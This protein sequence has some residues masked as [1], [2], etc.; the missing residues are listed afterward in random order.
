MKTLNLQK[1]NLNQYIRQESYTHLVIIMKKI[2]QA[3]AVTTLVFML[4][5]CS[6]EASKATINPVAENSQE[7][8]IVI[9][10]ESMDDDEFSFVMPSA[11]QI[12][13]I[14]QRTGAEYMD[15]VANPA[16]N[17]PKYATRVKKLL[18]LGIFT[19]DLAYVVLNSQTQIAMDYL[20]T[21][22][23]LSDEV[24]MSSVFNS[25][26]LL[27]RFERNIGE[28]D[29]IISI[30]AEIQE[31]TD[32]YIR[33]SDQDHL[34]MIIF[35]GAWV[36]GMYIG[37]TTAPEGQKDVLV[38]RLLEQTII[39]KNLNKGLQQQPFDTEEINTVKASLM[40]LQAFFESIE[41]LS[42]D[43]FNYDDVKM[44]PEKLN[45]MTEHIS[46]IRSS[47]VTI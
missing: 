8:E 19:S 7:E 37:L 43:N 23:Q 20:K 11:L 1:K 26:P 5:S 16:F 13:S 18:N 44:S 25:G 32:L 15:G 45:E 33:K 17:G 38:A 36:E 30:M 29:S 3:I 27:E 21:V 14:F 47:I 31:E 46:K 40:D 34:A 35:A 4:T 22:K 6:G 9:E 28:R 41:G 2:S 39:L 24:G 42:L 12:N 10:E